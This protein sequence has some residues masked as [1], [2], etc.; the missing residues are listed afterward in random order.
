MAPYS[1][2]HD[3]R[4]PLKAIRGFSSILK[5]SHATDLSS[6]AAR[7]LENIDKGAREM[8]QLVDGLLAFSKLGWDALHP[9]QIEMRSLVDAALVMLGSMRGDREVQITIEDMQSCRADKTL[10]QQVWVNLLSNALKYTRDRSPAV[11]TIG[12]IR[13]KNTNVFFV[14]DNGVGFDSK[15]ADTLFGVFQRLHRTEDYEG[16]GV[17][18]ALV[19][20]IIHRHGGRIW[21]EAKPGVGATF[22]FTLGEP[23]TS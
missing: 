8:E 2:S 14:E 5:E 23:V 16:T 17:G 19:Q 1:V 15:Y 7:Y 18:L 9:R 20:R 21:A 10:L 22:F 12:S 4:P 3:L 6:A 11:I 13:E